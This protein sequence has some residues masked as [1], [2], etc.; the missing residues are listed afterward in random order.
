MGR[1]PRKLD[2][3][4]S[5]AALFGAKVRK[6]REAQGWSQEQLGE[7]VFCTGDLIS[8]IELAV[9]SPSQQMAAAFDRL[10]GTG[11]YFQELWHLVNKET[12]PDWFRPYPDLEAEASSIRTFG[13]GLIDGLLQTEDYAREIFLTGQTPEKLDQ[14]LATRMKRQEIL[15]RSAPPR[16][17]GVLDERALCTGVGGPEVMKAQI[18]HL[19]E[20]A[21]RP[22]ITV[23]IVPDGRGAYL[24]LNGPIT[25]LSF[26]EGPDVAYFDNQAGGQLVEE[27]A[28][29]EGCAVRFEL[30]RASAL[31][32]EESLELLETILESL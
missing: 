7:K 2:P 3:T 6:H 26:D 19:I 8:K 22:N 30:I 13:F 23:Q 12:L 31:S 25:I 11:E 4:A 16:L 32:Q 18:V 29:V 24:G 1:R 28:T 15:T 27:A 9:R 10:F 20:L 14:L 5:A 21:Q 17:W